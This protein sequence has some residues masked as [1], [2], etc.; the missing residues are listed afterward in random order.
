MIELAHEG[1]RE[2]LFLRNHPRVYGKLMS[3]F[4]GLADLL[5]PVDHFTLTG[6]Y[7]NGGKVANF[8]YDVTD[9]PFTYALAHLEKC[10]I[11]FKTQF[12]HSFDE[13]GFSLSSDIRVGYHPYVLDSKDK[14]RPAMSTGPI[15]NTLNL[16]RN[17][18]QLAGNAAYLSGSK[19]YKMFASFG[20]DRGPSPWKKRELPTAPHNY[21]GEKDIMSR[22]PEITHPNEKRARLVSI[23]KGWK[24]S[25]V[26][27]R[28]WNT[29]DPSIQG[30]PLKWSDYLARVGE[31][32]WNINVSGFRRSLPFRFLDS[33]Q[34]GC[35]IVTDNLG[36]KWYRPFD[37]EFEVTEFGELGYEIESN[38]NWK[39]VEI[40]LRNIYEKTDLSQER[41]RA[42]RDSFENKWQP[43]RLGEYFIAE[44]E[45]VLD[46]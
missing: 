5:S 45:N 46:R 41:A 7:E 18:S 10:D 28:I 43:M 8:A 33:F 15:T 27:V 38:V 22:F 2:D 13:L 19:R 29:S 6:Y 21:L 14:L 3:Y 4:P 32:V 12:P 9:S 37:P 30:A 35:G 31:T 17:L 42:V 11:Y 44:C 40:R 16:K 1:A 39:S 34:V 36:V 26:D 25:D 23:L 20:G 24:K